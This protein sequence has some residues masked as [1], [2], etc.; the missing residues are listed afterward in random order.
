MITKR[1]RPRSTAVLLFSF[2][3]YSPE[4]VEK[5]FE[6]SYARAKRLTIRRIIAA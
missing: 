5:L 1:R 3:P 6:K 4:C 2:Q